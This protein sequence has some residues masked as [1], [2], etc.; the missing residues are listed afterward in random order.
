MK[1][2]IL[3]FVIFTFLLSACENT[4][5]SSKNPTPT[6]EN[7]A[8]LPSP[9]VSREELP[10]AEEAALSY[11]NLW[12]AE[13]YAGMYALLSQESQAA[14][15]QEDFTA[16][17]KK[18]A[19][20]VTMK[21]VSFTILSNL[22]STDNAQVSYRVSYDTNLI[23]VLERET[24]MNLSLVE[25]RWLVHWDPSMILPELSDGNY[26]E[27]VLTIPTRGNIYSSD[28]SNNYPLV[29]H[30]D[31]ASLV[32]VPG[33]INDEQEDS[34]VALL[35]ELTNQSEDAV[36]RKY[37]Y[38]QPE[39]SVTI[40]DISSEVAKE[41]SAR[42]DFYEGLYLRPFKSRFYYDNGI[43]PHV[44]GYMLSITAEN[45]EHYQR[46]GYKVDETVGASG[47]EL[48]GE[49][50]LAGTRGADLYVKNPEGR[51][52][53]KIASTEAKPAQSITTTIDSRLQYWLQRSMGDQ[54]GAVVVMERD[55]GRVL[56]MVS[57]PTFDPNIFNP[58]IHTHYEVAD[59]I[60]N[61]RQPLYNRA[62]QGVYPPGSIFK[63][64]SMVSALQTG[65]FTPDRVYNCDQQW[66]E[67]AGWVGKNWTLT[68]GFDA[69]GPLTLVEGLMRSCNPWF[70]HIGLTLWNDGYTSSIPDEAINYGFGALTGIEIEE[71]AGTVNYPDDAFEYF[72]MAIGQGTL[73]IN[74]LQ[75]A[76]LA[77]AIGNG[78]YLYRPT[79][80]E[81][82]S[83][84]DEEPSY[85][86]EPDLIRKVDTL[87]ENLEAI[88]DGMI[89]VI[90]NP[91]GTAAYQFERFSGNLAGKTGTAETSL[92]IPH[93]WFIGYTFNEDPEKPDIAI[94]VILEYAGEGSAMAAPLFRRAVSLYY[95]NADEPGVILPW[96]ERPYQLKEKEEE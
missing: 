85:V 94:A 82:I 39:W 54:V 19:I 10:D 37:A 75:A 55:T 18:T 68:W 71:V 59:L 44:T 17:H 21:T 96:E 72:Q 83:F 30:D 51:I 24:L 27:L 49:R 29:A 53:T 52:V 3:L 6:V 80:V 41:N 16:I 77:A 13:D 60:Q 87:P 12:S 58:L 8:T 40:G 45:Q 28:A 79:V 33:R 95:S 32:V 20:D 76:N 93:A 14:I 22:L 31:A 66:T 34:L 46:L 23:G 5:L 1:R 42:I 36:R 64:V 26:L 50:Y 91:R 48:W 70:W 35:A 11:L 63:V 65:V 2:F 62:T 47:L 90:R 69:D 86:F 25:D 56:A 84:M 38:A 67:Y 7:T 73:Q 88:Q 81:R 57:N 78:G 4:G 89:Q 43:A 92:G 61:V 9:M 15:S 74:A